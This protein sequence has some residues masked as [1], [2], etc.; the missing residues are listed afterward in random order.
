MVVTTVSVHVKPEHIN[1]FIAATIKNHEASINEPGNRRFD[2]LQSCDDPAAFLLYEAYDTEEA[3]AA[4]KK[5][6]H[7]EQWRNV[8]A[9]WMEI[10]RKGTPYKAIRP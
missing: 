2:V 7:Y 5:T 9:D 1:D 10:P 6:T 8:V 3:A 4:H